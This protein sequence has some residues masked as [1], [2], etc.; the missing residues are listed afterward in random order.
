MQRDLRFSFEN[1]SL[2]YSFLPVLITLGAKEHSTC[3]N[4]FHCP[5]VHASWRIDETNCLS[6]TDDLLRDGSPTQVLSY[7]AGE[8]KP[9][10]HGA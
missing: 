9:P 10:P 1:L 3:Y 2:G 4:G 5:D 8:A 7:P 6:T